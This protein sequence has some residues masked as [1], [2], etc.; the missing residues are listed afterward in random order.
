MHYGGLI[1]YEA[2]WQY[3]S[4]LEGT[5]CTQ[6]GND[7]FSQLNHV[8]SLYLT[9][10]AVEILANAQCRNYFTA[11]AKYRINQYFI[12]L[13]NYLQIPTTL[14]CAAILEEIYAICNGFFFSQWIISVE[15]VF[16]IEDRL[17]EAKL[18]SLNL[19]EKTSIITA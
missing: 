14:S 12:K 2:Q 13:I 1:S 19:F 15:R 16:T 18:I 11:I 7:F 17:T 3:L 6:V 8:Y 4:T 5:R 10:K 9:L